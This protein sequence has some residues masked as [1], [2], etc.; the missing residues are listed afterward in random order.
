MQ[1][2]FAK[3]LGSAFYK[4]NLPNILSTDAGTKVLGVTTTI[5]RHFTANRLKK[6]KYQKVETKSCCLVVRAL[7][8]ICLR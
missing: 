1:E 7:H 4:S 5:R 2:E 8:V 6:I 3:L